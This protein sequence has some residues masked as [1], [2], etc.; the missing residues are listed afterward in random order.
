TNTLAKA[1]PFGNLERIDLPHADQPVAADLVIHTVPDIIGDPLGGC[2][3]S[4]TPGPT[5]VA[6]GCIVQNKD[7]KG[8]VAR[9][10]TQQIGSLAVLWLVVTSFDASFHTH[11]SLQAF[12]MVTKCLWPAPVSPENQVVVDAAPCPDGSIVVADQTMAA[13][14]LHVYQGSAE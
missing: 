6:N 3:E 4:I 5:P 7:V 11:G 9:L 10:G 14:G 8:I 2:V 13:N 1:N 12:D